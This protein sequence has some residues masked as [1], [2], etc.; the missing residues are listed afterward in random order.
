MR[1]WLRRSTFSPGIISG[2]LARP[3]AGYFIAC[4]SQICI[5]A[6]VI[7]LIRTW[8]HIHFPE[9]LP[10]LAI[11][12]VALGW[13][14]GPS[15]VATIIGAL[16][17]LLHWLLPHIFFSVATVEDSIGVFIY[18]STGLM[19]SLLTSRAQRAHSRNTTEQE[20][21]LQRLQASERQA[22]ERAQQLEA[23]FEAMTDAVF[24]RNGRK[25]PTYMNKA[26]WDLLKLPPDARSTPVTEPPFSLVDEQGQP[27]P[28]N[29]W[30]EARLF[31][32]EELRGTHA[33]YAHL[34]TLDGE[35]RNVSVT[36]AP[37]TY[38]EDGTI[39][40]IVLVCRDETERRA[41]EQHTRKALEALLAMAQ[42]VVFH[43]ARREGS[44]PEQRLE[45]L[46]HLIQQL[47]DLAHRVLGSKRMS[48]S[49][50]EPSSGRNIPLAATGLTPENMQQWWNEVG[51]SSLDEYLPPELVDRLRADE[52]LILDLSKQPPIARA[53]YGFGLTLAVPLLS[54][55]QL[56][57]IFAIDNGQQT[58]TYTA[59]EIAVARAVAQLVSL[60]VER[61]RLEAER[62][63][64]RANVLAL[65]ETNRL[66][67]EFLSIAAHEIRTPLT[68][69]KAS[70]QLAQ[71]QLSR[72]RSDEATFSEEAK[73][74]MRAIYEL[75][76]RAERQASRQTRLVRDLLDVSR[77]QANHL[78]LRPARFNLITLAREVVSDQRS[79]LPHRTIGLE[80]REDVIMVQAD[81]DR[82]EQVIDNYLSNGLKYSEIDKPVLVKIELEAGNR[83][84]VLVR[85]EGPGLSLEQ[86]QRIWERFYRVPG[87][88][89]KCG[90]GIGLGLGLHISR[91]IIERHGGQVGI[92]SEP[93]HGAT[94]WFTLPIAE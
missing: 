82:I 69:I 46:Q 13:G 41:L 45:T 70:L 77:I 94:F 71:R 61:E 86:Q 40:G 90:S 17:I 30:P 74:H 55:D 50:L 24:I 52:A 37:L 34:R 87:I 63:E 19:I 8:P 32:G 68:T 42:M 78:Q 83:V 18:L 20:R 48:I 15:I 54:G 10:L 39:R 27:L 25:K 56:I 79:Q 81:R 72:L 38:V 7:W 1:L 62:T 2:P 58:R 84:H 23:V 22:A 80:V 6:I 11:M 12:L 16:L 59:E 89:V 64:A 53:Y 92:E 4:L 28:R 67:N 65:Q 33:A 66:M 5:L 14:T 91:S 35:I 21:L 36:G 9:A 47:A 26:A 93:E 31:R 76:E 75:L 73:R 43:P 3:A 57:G 60:V 51:S 44:S 85:D 49:L 29:Q 88:E